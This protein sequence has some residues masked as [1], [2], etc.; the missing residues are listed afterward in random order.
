MLGLAN[1]T[2]ARLCVGYVLGFVLYEIGSVALNFVTNP[3]F[4]GGNVF[5]M[6]MNTPW[7]IVS[8]I[9]GGILIIGLSVTYLYIVRDTRRTI[10]EN[11]PPAEGEGAYDDRA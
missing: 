8:A 10:L 11:R 7:M 3:M 5:Q 2:L 4:R 6:Q 1:R 9:W